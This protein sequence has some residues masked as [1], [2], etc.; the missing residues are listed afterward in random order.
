MKI[1]KGMLLGAVLIASVA[2]A[3]FAES[4]HAHEHAGQAS[5]HA[6]ER[7]VGSNLPPRF[8]ALIIQEMLAVTEASKRI[9]EALAR[10]Q[11]DIV[12]EN[13]QAIH[14]SFVLEQEMSE[15]DSKALHD[16]LPHSFVER[17]HEFHALSADL[18]NAARNGN[19]QEQL[20][21]FTN[22]TNACV[23]CHSAHAT[24]RFPGLAQK[25]Q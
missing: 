1:L 5:A 9:L 22:M 15:E 18:A 13:A 16:L 20:R 24:D 7:A 10:G 12:A 17:D 25:L 4:K 8:R 14:D 21:L 6:D 2:P 3:A 19:T 23:A 11:D